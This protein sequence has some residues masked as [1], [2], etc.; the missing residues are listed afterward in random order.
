M[1]CK[2][3]NVFVPAGVKGLQR[4]TAC[5][6]TADQGDLDVLKW[7][8]ENGC[9]WDAD[10]CSRAVRGCHIDVL[11]Y[12]HENGCPWD[13]VACLRAAG[14]GYFA[15]PKHADDKGCQWEGRAEAARELLKYLLEKEVASMC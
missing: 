9:P 6:M 1:T 11:K 8:H 13:R 7:L 5:S 2:E 15:R 4:S 12:L 10:T 3:F 14:G